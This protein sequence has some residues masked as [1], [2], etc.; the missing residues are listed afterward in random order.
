MKGPNVNKKDDKYYARKVERA[1]C[2]KLIGETYYV[3]CDIKMRGSNL[4]TYEKGNDYITKVTS[5]DTKRKTILYLE[6]DALN[7]VLSSINIIDR[8]IDEAKDKEVFNKYSLYY[9]KSN[10]GYD[11]LYKMTGYDVPS[12][13]YYEDMMFSKLIHRLSIQSEIEL[14]N[15]VLYKASLFLDDKKLQSEIRIQYHK[16]TKEDSD[17]VGA[18]PKTSESLNKDFI[19]YREDI[20]YKLLEYSGYRIWHRPYFGMKGSTHEKW[21]INPYTR[22]ALD[23]AKIESDAITFSEFVKILNSN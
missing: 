14:E 22:Y 17:Y 1:S 6:E 12:Y 2:C 8:V 9:R 18:L 13:K 23:A 10:N 7:T 11:F 3:T 19:I 5:P 20:D 16:D 4:Y 21:T 15:D